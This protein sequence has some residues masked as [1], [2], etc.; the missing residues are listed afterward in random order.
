MIT[1][2]SVTIVTK[3][4]GVNL[5]NTLDAIRDFEE[6]V[7]VYCNKSTRNYVEEI[8]KKWPNTRIIYQEWLGYTK[9]KNFA[10]TLAKNNFIFN[11]DSD[12]VPSIE[13]TRYLEDL[14]STQLKKYDRYWIRYYD[15]MWIRVVKHGLW[16][17]GHWRLYNKL[18]LRFDGEIHESLVEIVSDRIKS[19]KISNGVITHYSHRSLS[20]T[21]KKFS[22][23]SM[24][25]ANEIYHRYEHMPA[26]AILIYGLVLSINQIVIK[27]I[28]RLGI[29]EGS[30]GII[31][32]MMRGYYTMLVFSRL[33]IRKLQPFNLDK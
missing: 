8:R 16:G 3:N 14:S 13:L 18:K 24:S 26:L 7:L 10:A 5:F 32:A 22:E 9:Q 27:Y 31:M 29:L 12:E 15:Y 6:V 33:V 17:K 4:L 2:I 19:T 11:I 30:L 20:T 21:L 23:Y 1:N 25:E 28:L